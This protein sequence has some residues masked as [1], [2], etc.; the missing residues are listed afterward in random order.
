MKNEAAVSLCDL[1]SDWCLFLGSSNSLGGLSDFS[2]DL[3]VESFKIGNLS[4]GQ[5][6]FPTSELLLESVFVFLLEEIHVGL[7][8]G[9][10]DVFSVLLGVI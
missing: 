6:S 3:L 1:L 5:G 10:E 4:L 2:V 7:D 8:V 9:T